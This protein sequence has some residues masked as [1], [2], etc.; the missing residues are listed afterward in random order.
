MI[1]TSLLLTGALSALA[2]AQNPAVLLLDAGSPIVQDSHDTRA[3]RP[4]D[5]DGDGDTDLFV[6][7]FHQNDFVYRNMGNGTWFVV[8]PFNLTD[9]LDD[10][11]DAAWGD[12]D[13]DGDLD[14]A[15]ANGSK[16]LQ[17]GGGTG[18][19]NALYRNIGPLPGIEGRFEPVASS[20]V[21]NDL[22]E[23]YAVAW[24]D[25]DGDASQDL[26]FV[27][28]LQPDFL[29]LNDGSGQF[30]KVTTGPLVTDNDV[31][32]DVATGDLDGDGDEDIVVANSNGEACAIY[33]NQGHA[34]GGVEGEFARDLTGPL[35]ADTGDA[36]W[37]GDLHLRGR[38]APLLRRPKAAE[39]PAVARARE[40]SRI[41]SIFLDFSS[42]PWLEVEPGPEGTAVVWRDLRFERPGR[43]AFVARIVVAPDG[44]IRSESFRY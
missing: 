24:A 36:Y 32:R 11:F 40:A 4:A 7:N 9:N 26:V 39:D 29:Y 27:N 22:G 16:G 34:Q 30:T 5:I 14:L 23:T 25:F 1:R 3:I 35:A 42:F 38:S 18:T 15:V 19:N 12:M 43:E 13:A 17:P 33:V 31:S 10:T 21:A 6:G 28:R 44:T 41:A 8:P 2:A 37:V 20:P